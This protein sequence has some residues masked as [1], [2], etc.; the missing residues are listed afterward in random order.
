MGKID[1]IPFFSSGK[2]FGLSGGAK[3]GEEVDDGRIDLL[4]D[5]GL[6]CVNRRPGSPGG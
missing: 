5:R 1:R 6:A 2:S 3:C 4:E